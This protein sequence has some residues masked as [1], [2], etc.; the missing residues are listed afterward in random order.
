MRI[1]LKFRKLGEGR[2]CWARFGCCRLC[3]EATQTLS[4]VM[5]RRQKAE[6]R[7]KKRRF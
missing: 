7:R 2:V 4:C 5:Q 1:K 6:Q 3:C